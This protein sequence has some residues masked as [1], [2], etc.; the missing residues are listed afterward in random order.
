[1]QN[2]MRN[3]S[4]KIGDNMNDL[5]KIFEEINSDLFFIH[6]DA[7]RVVQTTNPNM[8][9]LMIENLSLSNGHQVLE[10]GTGSGYNSAIISKLVGDDGV[11]TTIEVDPEVAKN[12]K[13]RLASIGIENVRIITG[14]G[15]YGYGDHAKYDRIIATTKPPHISTPWVEQLKENGI[16]ITPIDVPIHDQILT[17]IVVFQK[18]SDNLLKSIKVLKGGF[19]PMAPRSDE[20]LMKPNQNFARSNN[21]I[22]IDKLFVQ[23]KRLSGEKIIWDG[24]K[25]DKWMLEVNE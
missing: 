2:V 11:V 18:L 3:H 13:K 9:A 16:L 20:L 17:I 15:W 12:A 14:D 5:K 7:S 4:K 22:D 21:D 1:M 10:I 23:A 24:S 25:W 8:M 19:I 6:P